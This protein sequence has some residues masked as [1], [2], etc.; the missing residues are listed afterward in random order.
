M[1]KDVLAELGMADRQEA[2]TFLKR[3]W[4]EQPTPC[5]RCGATLTFMHQKA[6]K[7]NCDWKCPD[8]GAV[9]K[10]IRILDGLN[11]G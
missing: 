10:T 6:K 1:E 4:H 3:L 2:L 7:S 5:P 8:C 9:Y 11:E